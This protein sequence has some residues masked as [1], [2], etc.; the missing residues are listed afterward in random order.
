MP[1]Y[2]VRSAVDIAKRGS[3]SRLPTDVQFVYIGICV[4]SRCRTCVVHGLVEFVSVPPLSDV[5]SYEYRRC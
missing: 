2:L 5:E 4:F 1:K 3:A